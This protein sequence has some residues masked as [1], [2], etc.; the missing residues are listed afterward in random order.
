MAGGYNYTCP[1]PAERVVFFMVILAGALGGV[2]HAMRSFFM[3]V[4]G[5]KLIQSWI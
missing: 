4:G 5:R 1:A 3:Y 2:L